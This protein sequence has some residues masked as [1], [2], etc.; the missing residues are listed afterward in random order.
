MQDGRIFS[1][2]EQPFFDKIDLPV[3]VKCMYNGT[4][5]FIGRVETKKLKESEK[6]TE[7]EKLAEIGAKIGVRLYWDTKDDIDF[8]KEKL[9][10]KVFVMQKIFKEALLIEIKKV[11]YRR[12][13]K[14]LGTHGE[15]KISFVSPEGIIK[16]V[17]QPAVLSTPLQ[18]EQDRKHFQNIKD[19]LKKSIEKSG[20]QL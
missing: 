17:I 7:L 3:P 19:E 2:I 11:N 16:M 1:K 20:I 15:Y 14:V 9:K 13:L 8:N 10:N 18:E 6:L 12:Y 4:K 5:Y